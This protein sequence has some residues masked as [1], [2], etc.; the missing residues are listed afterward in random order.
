VAG[1]NCS[2]KANTGPERPGVLVPIE[3]AATTRRFGESSLEL[4]NADPEGSAF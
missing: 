4:Q 2:V 1:N 3:F